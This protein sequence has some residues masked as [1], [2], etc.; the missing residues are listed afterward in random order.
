MDIEKINGIARQYTVAWNSQKPEN[1][2]AFF[3]EGATL[4][5]NGTASTGREAIAGVAR[6][7]R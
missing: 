7:F 4:F 2:A 5:V 1:I 3:T 6:G